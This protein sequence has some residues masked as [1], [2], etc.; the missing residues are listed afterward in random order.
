MARDCADI[1]RAL[2]AHETPSGAEFD[3]HINS[4][5]TCR[6]LV[7]HGTAV[8]EALASAPSP[9]PHDLRELE[10]RLL[11]AIIRERGLV[12]AVRSWPRPLRAGL[13]FIAMG[14][15]TF[16]FYHFFRRAD[17][18][19]YPPARMAF[20]LGAPAFVALGLLWVTLR[21]IHQPPLSALTTTALAGAGALLPVL[22]AV[23]PPLP[24]TVPEPGFTYVGTGYL[25]YSIGSGL[26]AVCLLV[27]R[28]ADRRGHADATTGILGALATGMVGVMAAQ[29]FCPVNDPLHLVSA[30]ATIPTGLAVLYLL[31]KRC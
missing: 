3:A 15:A 26:S 12:A 5:P 9:P 25:C 6:F 30:H 2:L 7:E 8:A 1:E 27:A 23:L 16:F 10:A 24:S 31:F 19:G 13:V 18:S 29:I 21:P 4:C 17:W 14:V 28:A 20:T 11:G 22:L